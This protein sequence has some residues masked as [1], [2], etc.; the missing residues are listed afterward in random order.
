MELKH[1]PLDRNGVL[2]LRGLRLPAI[3]L[4]G[5][6]QAGIVCHPAI[7]IEYQRAGARYVI[8]GVESGGAV[9]HLGAYCGF[10]DEAGFSLSI[11]Q[12]MMT[13]GVNGAHQA[14]LS[15]SLVR[16][17]MFRAGTICELLITHHRLVPVDAEWFARNRQVSQCAA[18]VFSS[19]G[20]DEVQVPERF[21]N[22]VACVTAGVCCAGCRHCHLSDPVALPTD[23]D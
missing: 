7:S 17:Q 20:G 23:V 22:A 4:R 12:P 5:L 6:Q 3:A 19:R 11:R 13:M 1:M 14:V 18:P 10:V 16:I 8:R 2:G 15:P 21:H 9:S